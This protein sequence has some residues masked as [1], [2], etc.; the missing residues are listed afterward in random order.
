MGNEA[1]MELTKEQ[2]KLKKAL[3]SEFLEDRDPS[4]RARH[5]RHRCSNVDPRKMPAQTSRVGLGTQAI[6]QEAPDPLLLLA[7]DDQRLDN[8]SFEFR[9]RR[10]AR[11]PGCELVTRSRNTVADART[12][13]HP[14]DPSI[15]KRVNH[16]ARRHRFFTEQSFTQYTT[17]QRRTFER[18]IY[19]YARAIGLSKAQA[20]IAL[21][22]ARKLCGEEEY[23]S[24]RT[25]LDEDEV[26]DSPA[27]GLSLPA[28]TGRPSGDSH[29]P[30]P[31]ERSTHNG[32]RKRSAVAE[33]DRAKKKKKGDIT[34][35]ND[36]PTQ[37]RRVVK[38]HITTTTM[39]PPIPNHQKSGPLG[40]IDKIMSREQL[41]STSD[42]RRAV[43]SG[44]STSSQAKTANM[45]STAIMPSIEQGDQIGETWQAEKAPEDKTEL[46]KG[47]ASEV[48]H[49]QSGSIP[50]P[51]SNPA[52]SQSTT[53]QVL[54]TT[55]G[56]NH[57]HAVQ[58]Q[59]VKLKHWQDDPKLDARK[60]SKETKAMSKGITLRLFESRCLKS[61]GVRE[62]NDP[63]TG[64]SRIP[65]FVETNLMRILEGF[66]LSY[67]NMKG[68]DNLKMLWARLL[69][70]NTLDQDHNGGEAKDRTIHE[71]EKEAKITLDGQRLEGSTQE[72][73]ER[74]VREVAE[75][76][77]E[78]TLKQYHETKTTNYLIGVLSEALNP[79]VKYSLRHDQEN[80]WRGILEGMKGFA[81]MYYGN[82][83]DGKDCNEWRFTARREIAAGVDRIFKR[84]EETGAQGGQ[85]P[86]ISERHRRM[87]NVCAPRPQSAETQAT[88]SDDS[89]YST[90]NSSVSE[91]D[92]TSSN[93]QESGKKDTI[94][95]HPP[96][97][98]IVDEAEDASSG[99]NEGSTDSER[100]AA[101]EMLRKEL[102]K[103]PEL[104]TNHGQQMEG[105]S[106]GSDGGPNDDEH[107]EVEQQYPENEPSETGEV[108]NDNE[109][110]EVEEQSPENEQPESTEQ[111]DE[112]DQA[113]S[114]EKCEEDERARSTDHQEPQAKV[115]QWL[116]GTTYPS[117][118][119]PIAEKASQYPPSV[120][121]QCRTCQ[122]SFPSRSALFRHLHSYRFHRE[123]QRQ[124]PGSNTKRKVD[125]AMEENNQENTDSPI[126]FSK[127][128]DSARMTAADEG[129]LWGENVLGISGLRGGD[130]AEGQQSI[131][132]TSELSS[133]EADEDHP[134]GQAASGIMPQ[135]QDGVDDISNLS[136]FSL[137]K[138]MA[139]VDIV[140]RIEVELLGSGATGNHYATPEL[141]STPVKIQLSSI[142]SSPLSSAPSSPQWPTPS[143]RTIKVETKGASHRKRVAAQR[144]SSHLTPYKQP[145]SSSKTSPYFQPSPKVPREAVS[146]IP[147]PP[148]SSTSFGLVQES[149]ASNPFH[150]LIA[151]IFLNKTRG[152]VAMPV[153]YAFITRF[154]NPESLAA[155]DLPDVVAFFQNLG[156]QNQRAKKCIALAKAW[157]VDQPAKGKRWRRLHY[158][159][160]GD[161]KDIKGNEEPIEDESEDG[162]VA[163]EVG[164]LPG[165]GAYGIDSWRIFCRDELRGLGNAA[166]PALPADGNEELRR[167]TETEEIGKEWTRVLPLD[168]ELRAYLRWRW[169][170][171]GWEWDPKTG[172][173]KRAEEKVV[174]GARGGGVICEGDQG[175][176]LGSEAK[177]QEIRKMGDLCG[178]GGGE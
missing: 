2:N 148:L 95:S 62:P 131:S 171:L 40:V 35:N 162:R 94:P 158:P 166:L 106:S 102:A 87:C 79:L 60:L 57:D 48:F 149:L 54:V 70:D 120:P 110:L 156:L 119:V 111:P 50:N 172:E 21:V 139:M 56:Q 53:S 152:A 51:L 64:K 31:D 89:I 25:Q 72:Q 18:D 142:A 105:E 75:G 61:S 43:A 88:N 19:D 175:W 108:S 66:I 132:S 20:K 47:K 13:N 170:R 92:E 81:L 103:I 34:I 98:K 42:T 164:H 121:S 140:K 115:Q 76:C 144:D 23:D 3:D 99:T 126:R 16:F 85:D 46:E 33:E 96:Q 38:N 136:G 69:N 86:G 10:T 36:S 178:S 134:P 17:S 68:F 91:E 28:S 154:P 5:S 124:A 155:A 78:S 45:Q 82:L 169:L 153:F 39:T 116:S 104:S 65:N 41:G 30:Q 8:T 160:V 80:V 97:E 137:S 143:R 127:S 4:R 67:L 73:H 147:F 130:A 145:R 133:V 123:P 168:K 24:D 12:A 177:E 129:V 71:T 138:I 174:E 1:S 93:S 117:Q 128:N 159:K 114:S 150:L 59:P 157:L 74:Y 7:T 84:D 22:Y 161:G 11:S 101:I 135:T 125:E 118:S 146:C 165:I 44:L 77:F 6:S 9:K 83:F 107:S 58:Q 176:S 55:Q 32:S 113:E 63:W 14:L 90:S 122:R 109:R 26:D 15:L 29:A 167:E 163:W 52:T 141:P 27:V 112:D 151:V 100:S 49:I 37:A 173:R